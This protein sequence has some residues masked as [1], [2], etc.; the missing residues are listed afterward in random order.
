MNYSEPCYY[1]TR[2]IENLESLDTEKSL[3]FGLIH[4]AIYWARNIMTDNL[5]K[6][7]NYFIL[8]L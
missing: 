2:L 4:K 8:I 6:V 5:E 1:S 7:E 3:D